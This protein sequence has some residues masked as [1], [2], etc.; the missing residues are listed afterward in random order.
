MEGKLNED[1]A[2]KAEWEKKMVDLSDAHDEAKN[3]EQTA[4]LTRNQLGGHFMVKDNAYQNFHASF[5]VPLSPPP[6]PSLSPSN[7]GSIESNARAVRALRGWLL[8]ARKQ[9]SV[10]CMLAAAATVFAIC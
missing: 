10:C 7:A 1:K 6:P 4:D 8:D 3:D 5:E 9:D 2:S